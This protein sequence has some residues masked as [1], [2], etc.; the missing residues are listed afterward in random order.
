MADSLAKAFKMH[1][2]FPKNDYEKE[3]QCTYLRNTI[4]TS[5]GALRTQIQLINTKPTAAQTQI[6][7]QLCYENTNNYRNNIQSNNKKRYEN[8]Q[9]NLDEN[10]DECFLV[11][12]PLKH[13][14]IIDSGYRLRTF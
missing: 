13:A 1:K 11:E 4:I 6:L 14:W 7:S 3:K 8:T 10:S 9:G 5:A 12:I 2:K